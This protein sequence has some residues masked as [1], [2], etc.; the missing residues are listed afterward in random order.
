[1]SH[2]GPPSRL[3]PQTRVGRSWAMW[4]K[5]ART[6]IDHAHANVDLPHH[7]EGDISEHEGHPL[8]GSGVAQSTAM[9]SPL[10]HFIPPRNRAGRQHTKVA[11]PPAT[12]DDVPLTNEVD[13]MLRKHTAGQTKGG[14][15]MAPSL[16]PAEYRQLQPGDPHHF[17]YVCQCHR[18][19]GP[20]VCEQGGQGHIV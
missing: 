9:S 19:C 18:R 14:G 17:R 7:G 15:F 10:L 5:Y 13:G 20:T 6:P 11:C 1:M 12:R 2:M 8:A 16:G 4:A 3:L